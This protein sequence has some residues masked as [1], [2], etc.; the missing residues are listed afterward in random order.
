ML[1]LKVTH[2]EIPCYNLRCISSGQYNFHCTGAIRVK[3]SS[4]CNTIDRIGR[5]LSHFYIFVH[6]VLEEMAPESIRILSELNSPAPSIPFIFI[7]SAGI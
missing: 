3:V 5:F 2:T 1:S 4:L 7:N 6:S